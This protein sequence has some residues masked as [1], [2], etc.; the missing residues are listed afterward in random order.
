VVPRRH[1]AGRLWEQPR[2]PIEE[3]IMRTLF[4]MTFA[5]ALTA[6]AA[7]ALAQQ[8]VFPTPPGTALLPLALYEIDYATAGKLAQQSGF[9][10]NADT[11]ISIGLGAKAPVKKCQLQVA[12]Y[13]W[14]GVLAGV[15]GPAIVNAGTTLEFTTSVNTGNQFEY[16]PFQENVFSDLQGPF[17][18]YAQIRNDGNCPKDK[19]RVDAEFAVLSTLSG[20]AN[21]AVKYKS[22]AVTNLAGVAGY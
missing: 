9:T 6:I 22:I 5:A 21:Y 7:P 15:S 3:Y 8:P 19:L 18:G 1:N 17:E 10:G 14:N 13:D 12:W 16:E 4:R 20:T 11:I 2:A